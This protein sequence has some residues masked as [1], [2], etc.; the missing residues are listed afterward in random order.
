MCLNLFLK[1]KL[2]KKR[3]CFKFCVQSLQL[4][5][6]Q[7]FLRFKSIF[8]GYTGRTRTLPTVAGEE[9]CNF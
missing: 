7:Y 8:L 5:K 1:V 4:H 3:F 9:R 6:N 2:K